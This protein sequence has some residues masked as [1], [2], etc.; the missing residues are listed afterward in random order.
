MDDLSRLEL[1][2]RQ[3]R[4]AEIDAQRRL[5]VIVEQALARLDVRL[6]ALIAERTPSPHPHDRDLTEGESP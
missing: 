5:D 2:I 3:N 6:R 4:Q 1:R